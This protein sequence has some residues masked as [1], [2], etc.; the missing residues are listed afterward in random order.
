MSS[1]LNF[2][3]RQRGVLHQAVIS[4]GGLSCVF[5]PALFQ[6]DHETID[7]WMKSMGDGPMASFCPWGSGLVVIDLD[8]KKIWDVQVAREL[9]ALSRRFDHS[10]INLKRLHKLGWLGAGLVNLETGAVVV[11]YPKGGLSIDW[12][13]EEVERSDEAFKAAHPEMN[14]AK[15]DMRPYMAMGQV[16]P[17][18]PFAPKGWTFMPLDDGFG[19]VMKQRDGLIADGF[20]IT[21]AD[22]KGWD[23]WLAEM[24]QRPT[25]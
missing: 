9:N 10:W 24:K 4:S 7:A 16:Q 20:P 25:W 13:E 3:L 2:V 17:R 1:L 18:F 15:G 11:P 14:W 21:Q 23:E 8:Q 12:Y 6:G 19:N 22:F 5:D